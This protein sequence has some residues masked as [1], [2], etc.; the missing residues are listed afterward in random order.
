MGVVAVVA[1]KGGVVSNGG[2]DDEDFSNLETERLDD[3]L[4][5]GGVGSA[6]VG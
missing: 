5:F 4:G 3:N 1:S 6:I 2:D